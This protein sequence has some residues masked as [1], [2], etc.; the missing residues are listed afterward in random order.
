M[1]VL[2]SFLYEAM[3]FDFSPRLLLSHFIKVQFF[4]KEALGI[5]INVDW[6]IRKVKKI[7]L[8]L[9]ISLS[10]FKESCTYVEALQWSNTELR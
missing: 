9:S 3:L 4:V 8:P 5:I 1:Y 7:N 10:I 2:L 6:C